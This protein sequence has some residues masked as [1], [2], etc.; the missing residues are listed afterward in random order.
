MPERDV[1]RKASEARLASKRRH[2]AHVAIARIPVQE[3]RRVA[4]P[5]LEWLCGVQQSLVQVDERGRALDRHPHR[6]AALP[7]S[8]H[9]QG[10]RLVIAQYVVHL[11]KH[12]VEQLV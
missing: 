1:R 9:T 12:G 2:P 11:R 5:Q 4:A 10:K 8:D 6:V 7:A 3:G